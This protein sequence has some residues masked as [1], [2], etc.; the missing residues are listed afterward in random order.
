MS[1][2]AN[3]YM[4]NPTASNP[5]MAQQQNASQVQAQQSYDYKQP[6]DA[7]DPLAKTL[8][9][10]VQKQQLLNDLDGINDNFFEQTK[11]SIN[12]LIDLKVALHEHDKI[13]DD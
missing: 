8:N 9:P 2:A 10:A 12:A 6:Q 3:P 13:L 11:N 5:Y 1:T 7:V 4:A